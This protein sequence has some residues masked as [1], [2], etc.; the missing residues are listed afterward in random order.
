LLVAL[1]MLPTWGSAQAVDHRGGFSPGEDVRFALLVGHDDGGPGTAQ[2]FYAEADAERLADVL[3]Q[4]GSIDP[5][6]MTLLRSPTATGFDRA[7]RA[8]GKDIAAAKAAGAHVS[9]LFYYSGHADPDALRLGRETVPFVALRAAL[10]ETGADARLLFLDSCFSGGASRAKG[11]S[12]APGFLRAA[13]ATAD[14]R[15]EVV[16]TS[17]AADE[18][19]QESDEVGGSYFTHYLISALRGA[20]DTSGDGAVTLDEA[21]RY[22]YHRTVAHTSGTRAGTQHPGFDY[23][24]S[25]SGD[26]VLTNLGTRGA[27]LSFGPDED[28]RF[29]IFDDDARRFVAEVRVMAGRPTRLMV[30]AGRYRIQLRGTDALHEQVV[31]LRSGDE[32]AVAIAEL[33]A[34]PYADDV[35]KGHIATYRRFRSRRGLVI[36]PKVG[37][38]FFFD[39]ETRDTL[40]PPLPLFGFEVELRGFPGPWASVRADVLVGFMNHKPVLG[41]T[42][43]EVDFSEVHAGIGPFLSPRLP[44]TRVV[45]PFVGLRVG[46]LWLHR[47]FLPP[48]IQPPQDYLMVTPGVVAGVEFAFTDRVSLAIE[49]R[50]HLMMYVVDEQQEAEGHVEPLV[51]MRFAL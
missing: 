29:L 44:G 13:T 6:R 49:V 9:L 18:A 37:G 15:G 33:T 19:S 36:S 32:H 10:A 7:L 4:L 27:A 39:P 38:Q 45:R 48:L 12:R 28:G 25:G 1:L 31:S 30:E 3:K 8:M 43:T 41:G 50:A 51:S 16:I 20:A 24:L 23:D 35:T 14:V 40:V 5:S 2:L 21:Y 22:V 46:L 47:E 34:V 42:P 11:A 26:V 17:S